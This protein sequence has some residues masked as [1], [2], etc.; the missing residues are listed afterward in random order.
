[1]TDRE[2]SPPTIDAGIEYART[3]RDPEFRTFLAKLGG[4]HRHVVIALD[5]EPFTR[6]IARMVHNG[7]E[8]PCIIAIHMPSEPF[9]FGILRAE[10]VGLRRMFARWGEVHLSPSSTIG[11]VYSALKPPRSF[12]PREWTRM[13]KVQVERVPMPL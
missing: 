6:V 12:V 11:M 1:M 2:A 10:R 3:L 5:G 9:G 4:A 13:K 7:A 8:S